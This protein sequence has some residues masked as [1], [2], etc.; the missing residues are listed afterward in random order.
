MKFLRPSIVL[1]LSILAIPI[2]AQEWDPM[3]NAKIGIVQAD[4]KTFEV[5]SVACQPIS[6]VKWW[7]SMTY[8]FKIKGS[9]SDVSVSSPTTLRLV[10]INPK[11]IRNLNLVKLKV[12]GASRIWKMKATMSD[13]LPFSD[14]EVV[15]VKE[16]PEPIK[17]EDG[18]Y[19]LALPKAMAAGEYGLQIS[20]EIW[21]FT[22]K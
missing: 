9:K 15:S 5:E 18:V 11:K 4:G 14:Y 7:A 3:T 17:G 13:F 12:D 2:Q 19:T 22:V 10:G 8:N 16:R 21:D 6:A 1:A 20:A